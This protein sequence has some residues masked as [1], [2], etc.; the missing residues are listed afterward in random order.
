MNKF[1]HTQH[2]DLSARAARASSGDRSVAQLCA[3]LLLGLALCGCAT[4]DNPANA[5]ATSNSKDAAVSEKSAPASGS[6]SKPAMDTQVIGAVTSP[7]SDFNLIRTE[8]SPELNAAM[9]GPYILPS[10]KSCDAIGAEITALDR[11]IGPDLDAT[12]GSQ[13]ASLFDQGQSELSNAA[14]GALRSTV[15][16]VIPFRS[17]IRRFSGADKHSKDV[18]A[19]LAAGIVRRAFLKGLG[20]A[21]GCLPPAAPLPL[22]TAPATAT[23]PAKSGTGNNTTALP[24]ETIN[25]PSAPAK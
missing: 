13:V 5:L 19:A 1:L 10:D 17:W 3:G 12:T 14:V 25:P 4:A 2:S 18:T 6:M 16:G 22:A 9:K 15:E 20:Q 8:I 23:I 7:L 24:A 21:S 11:I